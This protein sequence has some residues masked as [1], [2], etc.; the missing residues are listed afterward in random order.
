MV[1]RRSEARDEQR[2]SEADPAEQA[3]A[4]DVPPVDG[5]RQA[6]EAGLIAVFFMELRGASALVRLAALAGLFWLMLLV[7]LTLNDFLTRTG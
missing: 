3:D 5:R 2:D 6:A 7:G 1:H 4:G